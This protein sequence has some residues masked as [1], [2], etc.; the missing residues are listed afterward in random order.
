M[1][2]VKD[3]EIGANHMDKILVHG[4]YRIYIGNSLEDI[5]LTQEITL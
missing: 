2:A 4:E 1:F 5:E 3:D